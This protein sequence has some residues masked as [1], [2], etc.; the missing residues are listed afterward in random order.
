MNAIA[1]S[2]WYAL[3]KRRQMDVGDK[4]NTSYEQGLD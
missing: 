4:I 2:L 3:F 1:L